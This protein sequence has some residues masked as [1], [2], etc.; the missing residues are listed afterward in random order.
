MRHS[1]VYIQVTINF[2]SQF[3]AWNLT[4]SSLIY[5]FLTFVYVVAVNLNNRRDREQN[6]F[7]EKFKLL[8]ERTVN[9]HQCLYR[10]PN[11][12]K[13]RLLQGADR[14]SPLNFASTWELLY[15]YPCVVISYY[16]N[17]RID[18]RFNPGLRPFGTIQQVLKL[19]LMY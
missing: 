1:N 6:F 13:S 8:L 17:S 3:L 10:S 5:G 18:I 15:S 4:T 7:L 2:P 11:N 9:A 19:M 16:L 14:V 12:S